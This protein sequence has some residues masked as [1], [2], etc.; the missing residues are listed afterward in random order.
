M[1]FHPKRWHFQFSEFANNFQENNLQVEEVNPM[2]IENKCLSTFREKFQIV[3]IQGIF[4]TDTLN[5]NCEDLLQTLQYSFGS[6]QRC[7]FFK[8]FLPWY[9]ASNH[10]K[11]FFPYSKFAGFSISSHL[12]V[13]RRVMSW[14]SKGPTPQCHVSLRDD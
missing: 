11:M 5:V 4:F 3:Q 9:I 14:E 1:E 6:V 12:I 13:Y 2:I 10:L 7:D 8:D